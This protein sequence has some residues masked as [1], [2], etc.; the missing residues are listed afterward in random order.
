M[1]E[2]YPDLNPHANEIYKVQP[3]P[4]LQDVTFKELED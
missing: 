4:T 3:D 1:P 2:G